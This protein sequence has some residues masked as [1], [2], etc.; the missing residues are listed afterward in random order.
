[1]PSV[2]EQPSP[3]GLTQPSWNV[4]QQNSSRPRTEPTQLGQCPRGIVGPRAVD[5]RRLTVMTSMGARPQTG[6][7]LPPRQL[8]Q[9]TPSVPVLLSPA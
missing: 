6:R 2:G 5:T 3:Q 1:M 9:E 7:E 4:I 8:G